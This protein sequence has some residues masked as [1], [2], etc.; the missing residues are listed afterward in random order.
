MFSLITVVFDASEKVDKFVRKEVPIDVIIDYYFLSFLPYV[1]NLISPLF[2][3]IAGLY[4][5]SRMAYNSEII[6][7]LSGGVSFWRLLRPYLLVALLLASVDFYIKGWVV[8]NSNQGMLDFERTY[9]NKHRVKGNNDL[10]RRI[11]KGRFFS[12]DSYN[13]KDSVGRKFSYEEFDG[14]DLKVKV[15][16]TWL[17]WDIKR[18]EWFAHNYF[19][20]TFTETGEQ[21]EKGDTLWIDI[22]MQPTD[23][24]RTE[25]GITALTNPEL[26]DKIKEETASGNPDVRLWKVEYYQR[27]AFPFTSF[28]LIMIAVAVSS[29]KVRGGTGTHLMLGLLI[30]VTFVILVRFTTTFAQKATLDPLVAVWMPNV[31]FIILATVMLIRAPK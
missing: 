23:F 24:D 20:R 18:N 2:I 3:F 4:F 1:L 5:T 22:K 11:E 31:F 28:V 21:I 29:R 26:R 12:F 30:A 16:S 9:L 6:A 8:P 7:L 15:M 14:K 17:R 10:H 19:K 13:Y 25:K 27:F